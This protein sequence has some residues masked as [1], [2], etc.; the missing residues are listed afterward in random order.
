MEPVIVGIDPGTR[1]VGYCVLDGDGRVLDLGVI[2]PPSKDLPARLRDIQDAVERLLVR[3]A[4]SA[5][6]VERVYV[7]RNAAGAL[8][9]AGSRALAMA[10]AARVGAKVFEYTAGEAKRAVTGVGA[11]GKGGVQRA[12]Q[13]LLGLAA[14]PPEDAADAAALALCHAGRC[15]K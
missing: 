7:G 6:A 3:H 14:P 15:Y 2:A 11:G 13:L 5:M 10:S 9:L 12:V 1:R 8:T 4:P